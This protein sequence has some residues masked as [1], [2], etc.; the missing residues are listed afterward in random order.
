MSKEELIHRYVEAILDKRRDLSREEL[1]RMIEERKKGARVSEAYREVW[2]V[3]SIANELG[4]R[5]EDISLEKE[6]KIGNIVSGLTNISTRGR[7]IAILDIKEVE[8]N[9][10]KISIARMIIGDSSGWCYL[11]LWREKA[12]LLQELDVKVGDVIRI[13]KAY[14]KEG[15]LGTVEVHLGNVGSISK[16]NESPDVPPRES[17][18]KN[19]REVRY[20]ENLVNVK[21]TVIGVS[22]TKKFSSFRGGEG[23]VRRVFLADGDLR[24]PLTLW[25]GHSEK[26]SE[27][28][29]YSEVLIAGA[30]VRRGLGGGLELDLDQMGCLEILG[31][32]E[33]AGFSK[34][35]EVKSSKPVNMK[36]QI[37]KI[38]SENTIYIGGRTRRLMDMIVS[39]GESYGIL[40]AW[41]G[42]ID[43]FKQM[44]I[45]RK[46]V[47]LL[48]L[49]PRHWGKQVL[50]STTSSTT[51]AGL[52]EGLS[53]LKI[54]KKTYRIDELEEGLRKIHVEGVVSSKP[55]EQDISLS[56]GERVKVC[57]FNLADDTGIV[58]VVAWRE[59]I[60]KLA[61]L[62]PGMSI[63]IKWCNIRSRFLGEK[64][65]EIGRDSE[66]ELMNTE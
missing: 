9:G 17:F 46:K 65:V 48:N 12:N 50:L 20:D 42:I 32:R 43:K 2:A 10:E 35:S 8:S 22:D 29:V 31:R 58:E 40:T 5:L 59:N 56:S 30:R 14:S 16:L 49:I 57:R 61:G 55:E 63:R 34:L 13:S 11:Y 37:L 51:I 52:E 27:K 54:P 47:I 25:H 62:E 6:I 4:V 66:V 23:S 18:F 64:Y 39:D 26:I 53:D 19:L 41:D 36:L 33:E 3:F 15:R 24:I 28:D 7:I 45:E 1:I 21:A 38:F 60:S 44:N